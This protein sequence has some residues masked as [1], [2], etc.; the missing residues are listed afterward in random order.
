MKLGNPLLWSSAKDFH[1]VSM[2]GSLRNGF[3]AKPQSLGRHSSR[4]SVWTFTKNLTE[5]FQVLCV[6]WCSPPGHC[7]H[8]HAVTRSWDRST[9]GRPGAPHLQA[10]HLSAQSR[11]LTCPR[12]HSQQGEGLVPNTGCLLLTPPS[13]RGNPQHEAPHAA[14]SPGPHRLATSWAGPCCREG[15]K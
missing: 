13:S 12:S 3:G 9:R 1:V 7:Q 14:G 15:P 10:R 5:V 6:R 8:G 11:F 4:E 2:P